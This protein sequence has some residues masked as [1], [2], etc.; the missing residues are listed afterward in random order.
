MLLEHLQR[1]FLVTLQEFYLL[2]ESDI[3]LEQILVLLL[4]PNDNLF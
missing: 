2:L 1:I 3:D 4:F